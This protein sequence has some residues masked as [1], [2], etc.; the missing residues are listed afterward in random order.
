MVS[1]SM[2]QPMQSRHRRLLL[3]DGSYPYSL[4]IPSDEELLAAKKLTFGDVRLSLGNVAFETAA[5]ESIW[6]QALG[7][8]ALALSTNIPEKS[9]SHGKDP[10]DFNYNSSP[11]LSLRL[12]RRPRPSPSKDSKEEVPVMNGRE[13]VQFFAGCNHIGKIKSL[14][15]NLSPSRHFAP[16]DL[17]SVPKAKV[18]PEHYVFSSFGVLHVYP[19]QPSESMTLAEWQREAVLW[20]AV[21]AIPFFKNFLI[22][23][24]FYRWLK[25]K[26]Y[27]DY[28]RRRKTVASSLLANIPTFGAALQQVSR[29][30]KELMTVQFLPFEKDKTYQLTEYEN[31]INYKN[32]QAEHIL[33]KFFKYCKMVEDTVAEES[34]RKMKYCEEQVKKKTY[35][36]KDSLH[37]QTMKKEERE[38]NLQ[39]AKN[40]SGRLGNFVKLVDQMVVEHLFQITKSQVISFVKDVLAIDGEAQRDGFF[41]ANL[42]FNKQDV[43]CLSPSKERF[44]K[45]LSSTLNGIPAVLCSCA[46]PKDGSQQDKEFADVDSSSPHILHDPKTSSS[47]TQRDIKS[48]STFQVSLYKHDSMT[49]ITMSEQESQI[50]EG[51]VESSMIEQE[52]WA[53]TA[54]LS[55]PH[56]PRAD[57][58]TKSEDDLGIATPDL[59]LPSLSNTRLAIEGEGFLGQ[60]A[61]LSQASLEDKLTLDEE[62]Q[63]A[64]KIQQNLMQSALDEIETYCEFN[65]WLNEIHIFCRTWNEKS[66]KEFRGAVAFTIEQKLTEIRQWS[67]KVR[68]F[69]RSFI[70]ENGMFFVD[71]SAVHEGLLPCLNHIYQEL[72]AFVADEAKSLA[73]TFCEEMKIVLKNMKDKRETVESFAQFAK[74]Y[75]QYKKNTVQF[76]QRVEYI[77]SL[78]EVI[79]MSY[80]QLTAEEEK[81]EESVWSSW[82]AFLM[83]MQDAGEFIN[84][85]TPLMTQQLEETF[86]TLEKEAKHLAEQATSGC[87]LDSNQNPLLVLRMMKELREKFFRTQL[88]LQEASQWREAIVGDPYNLKF[89]SEMTVRMDVRQ[90]L[91]KYIDVSSSTIKDW[92]QMLFRKMNIKK[93]LERVTEWLS[94]AAQL[95]PYLPE[96]DKVLISWYSS[97]QDFRKDLPVLFKL[98]NDALKDRHWHAIFL[99]MNEPYMGNTQF[100]VAELMSYNLSENAELVHNVYL[101][102]IAEYDLEQLMARIKSLWQDKNF[103]IAKHI[104]DSMFVKDRAKQ[105]GSV[106][107]A[108]KMERYRQERVAATAG[109]PHGL[110][111][112]N[113]DLYVL[114]E[115]E[116]LKYQLE[117]SRISV[118][119]ML[120]SPYIGDI[121]S[122]AKEWSSALCEIEEITDLWVVCQK[123]WLYLLKI[124]EQ[125]KLYRKLSQ[126][127]FKF[128]AVHAKFKDWMRVV[129]NDSKVLSVVNRRRGEKGYRLLQGDNLC[130]LFLSLIQQ[131]D[132]IL[133][134]L[135]QYLEKHR[136][137]FPRL[138]FLSNGDLIDM[139][140]VSRS[141]QSLLPF[142]RKCFPGVTDMS[143]VLPPDLEGLNSVLDFALNSDKLQVACVKG[144]CGEEVSL[145]KRLEPHPQASAWLYNLESILKN[146]MTILLQAC[147]QVCMEEGTRQPI[148]ILEELSRSGGAQVAEM[149]EI[150]SKIRHQ[151]QHWLLHFPAQCVQI[152]DCIL[153]ERSMARILEKTDQEEMKILRCNLSAKIDQY[154]DVLHESYKNPDLDNEMQEHLSC[155]LSSLV[156]QSIHHRDVMDNL[157]K[158]R[159]VVESNFDWLKVLKF[160]MDI[161]NVLRAK[162]TVNDGG[163]QMITSPKIQPF[164]K[165]QG[166]TQKRETHEEMPH[167]SRMK[168]TVSTDYDFSP[169][170]VQQLT[171][172]FFYDYEYLGPS[173]SLVITPLTERTTLSLTQSLRSFHCSMLIGPSGTGKTDIIKH[174]AKM[175]GR[176]MFTLTCSDSVTLPVILQYMTGMVQSGCWALFDDTDHLTKGLLSVAAQQLDYLHTAFRALDLSSKNQYLIRGQPRFDKKSGVGDKVIRRNSLT[177]LHPLPRAEA[178]P[179]PEL[180]RQRTVPHGFNEKGLVTYFEDT[181][182]AEREQRRHSIEREIEIKESEL[183]KNNR[184]PPLFY[185]HV[186]AG[187]RRA[188][189][190]Y[191]KLVP[192]PS[193]VRRY[194]G[195]VMFNGKLILANSNFGGFMTMGMTGN[196]QAMFPDN[197]RLLMRPCALIKP[198]TEHIFS[199]LLRIYSFQEYVLWARKLTL[200]LQLMETKLPRKTH[201]RWSLHDVKKIVVMASAKYRDNHSLPEVP[202]KTVKE[203]DT[204]AVEERCLV[205]AL[206][207]VVGPQVAEN[208]QTTL[209]VL[210]HDLFPQVAGW[211]LK[212]E[213]S[214]KEELP[215]VEAIREVMRED[216][217]KEI[218]PL[219][220]K[221]L[222]LNEGLESHS[223]VTLVGPA[224]SGKTTCF[225]ILSRA[226]NL[227]NYKLFA[228]DHCSDELTMD[229]NIVMQS[230]PRLKILRD[231]EAQNVDVLPTDCNEDLKFKPLTD[232]KKFH[233]LKKMSSTVQSSQAAADENGSALSSCEMARYPKVDVV[234]LVPTAMEPKELLGHFRASVWK[235]G[236]LGKIALDSFFM[237]QANKIYIESLQNSDRKE[238]KL[239]RETPSVLLRW[240]VLDGDLDSSW[241]DGMKTLFDGD[242]CLS[243]ANGESIQLKDTT[244]L[245]F[246]TSSLI[247]ASPAAVSRCTVVNFGETTS[248][249][250][251]L[252]HTWKQTAK[253]RWLLTAGSMKILDDLIQDVFPA[254]IRFLQTDCC[255]AL[256]TDLGIVTARVNAMISG[257]AEVSSF[258]KM[259]SALLDRVILREDLEKKA[260]LD[261][262]RS[263]TRLGASDGKVSRQ[264]ASR[265][266][267]SSQIEAFIPHYIDNIKNM[268]A[269]AFIWSFGGHLHDRF[270]DKFSKFVHDVLYRAVHSICLPVWGQVFDYC[271]DDSTGSFIRWSDRQQDKMKPVGSAFFLTPEVERYSY[272]VDL[273]LAKNHPVLLSGAPGVGKTALVNNMV[274]SR[275]PSST[276][277]LSPGVSASLLQRSMLNHILD[278]QSK[279][280]SL[281]PG[282]GQGN[283]PSN[284]RHL[285]FIDDLNMAPTMGSYQPPV[286]LLRHILC[287]GGTYDQ[288]RQAFQQMKEASFIAAATL[289]SAAGSGLGLATHVLS[290]RLLR[291]FVNLTIF[292]PNT[293]SLLTIYSRPIQTWLEEFPAYSVEHH[294]EFAKALT[295][296]L[297]ELYN[298]VKEHLRP[299]PIH[300]HYIY[301]LHDISRVVHGILLMSPRSHI[302]KLRTHKKGDDPKLKMMGRTLSYESMRSRTVSLS[303]QT[304]Q[305]EAGGSTSVMKLITQLWCHECTRNFGDR[306][307][308]TEDRNW[309]VTVLEE[310]AVKHFCLPRDDPRL[311][312]ASIK[313]E[314]TGSCATPVHTLNS[315]VSPA[316][317]PV[318]H[319]N[320]P[321]SP[322]QTSVEMDNE[323]ATESVQNKE[324]IQKE[325]QTSAGAS[326]SVSQG[327][328]RDSKQT[329]HRSPPPEEPTEVETHKPSSDSLSTDASFTMAA[330]T[331][332]CTTTDAGNTP[333]DGSECKTTV[334]ETHMTESDCK[335]EMNAEKEG[336]DD[337]EWQHSDSSEDLSEDTSSSEES[338]TATTFSDSVKP[339]PDLLSSSWATEDPKRKDDPKSLIKN[340]QASDKAVTAPPQVSSS[341]KHLSS[342]TGGPKRGVTFKTGLIADKEDD[343]YYGPLLNVEDVKGLPRV[344]SDFVFSKYFLTCHTETMDISPEKGYLESSVDMLGEALQ[345][346]LSVYNEG[347]SQQLNLVFFSEAVHHAARLS[348]V[349]AHPQ[350]HALLLGMSY[351]TGRATLTRL[352][353]YIAHCKLFEPKPHADSTHNLA[354]VAEHMKRSCYHAGVMGKSTV[355][356]LHEDLGDQCLPDVSALMAQG[357]S[358]GLYS[359]DEVQTIVGHM[360]PGGVQ[361]KRADKIEQA[362]QRFVKRV[363]QNLHIV[364]CLNYKGNSFSSDFHSMNKKLQQHPGLLKNA[365]SVDVYH[366]WDFITFSH[367]ATTW[368]EDNKL[369]VTIPWNIARHNEQM[370][371]A[372]DAMAYIH[373][374]A[375][376]AVDRQY[377]H[378]REPLRFYSPL[379]FLEFVHLFKVISAYIVKKEKEKATKYEKALG[380]INEAFGSIA[381][382]RQEVSDLAPRHKTANDTVRSLVED[383][384]KQKQV[385][386]QSLERCKAQEE[387]ITEM[388]GPL[389]QL[390]KSAQSEFDKVNPVYEAAQRA[391]DALNPRDIDEIKSFPSPPEQVKFLMRALCLMFGKPQTWE[392]SKVLLIRENFKQ[393][394]I[395]YDKDN[396]P[397][398]IFEALKEFVHNPDFQ[399]ETM[400]NISKAASGLSTWVIAI[401]H[402]SSI[403]RKMQPHLKNLLEA[404]NKFTRVQAQ[405]GQLRVEAHGIKSVLEATIGQHKEA[406]KEA[407]TIEKTIQG[408]ERR[409]A[410]ASNLMENMSMQHFLWRAE[411]KKARRHILAA[412]GDAL[413][414][415]ACVCYHGPLDDKARQ[416]L[417]TDW[418]ERCRQGTFHMQAF[419]EYDPYSMI[420]RLEV[421]LETSSQNGHQVSEDVQSVHSGNDSNFSEASSTLHSTP[422]VR[423]FKYM[424]AIYDTSKF[425]KSELKKT[426][427]ME[428][429]QP[430]NDELQ[431]SDDEEDLSALPTRSNYTI[432]DILSDFDELSDWRMRSLPTDLHAQQNALLMRV[433][434][435]NRRHCWPLLLDP[436][437]QA[438]MWVKALQGSRNT[439]NLCDV[440]VEEDRGIPLEK[441]T[442]NSV[443]DPTEK[444]PPE[445]PPS[446]GTAL[447]LSDV[448]ERTAANSE[449]TLTS[450][451]HT[452]QGWTCHQ[453]VVK[454]ELRPVTSVTGSWDTVNLPMDTSME[455]N[456]AG[457]WVVE[458]DDPVI[459]SKLVSAI[460]HGVTVLVTHLERRPLAAVFRG[461]LLKQFYVDHE[462][463]KVV[464][465]GDMQFKIHP[466]FCLY[467]S[468]T[469]PLFLKGDGLY[470]VPIHRMCIINMAVS[471]EAIINRLLY[472]TMKVERKEFEGQRRSNENDII[473]HRQR[474]VQEHEAIR[475]KTLNLD[476]PL[477]DDGTMLES[478]MKC[479]DNVQ[480]NRII[481][482][483]TRYMG[484]HLQD[485]FTHYLPLVVNGT[486]LYNILQCL[487]VLHSVYYVPFY[488]FVD[489]FA[490]VIK[491]RDRGKGSLGAPQARAQEL[492]DAVTGAV[493][494]HASMM[495]FELHYNL[496]LLLVSLERL[497]IERKA[498]HKELSLFVNGFEKHGLDEAGILEQKPAWMDSAAWIDCSI[499][500][501]LHHPFHGLCSSLVHNKEQWREYFQLPVVL[502]NPVP[503]TTLQELSIFQKCLLWKMCCPHRMAELAQ[504]IVTYEL[505]SAA[506]PS[507]HYN[508]REVYTS[509]DQ[510]TPVV[511]ILPTEIQGLAWDAS[512]GQPY[513]SPVHEVKRLAREVGMEGKVRI[514]NFG[515][516]SQELEVRQAL[517]DCIHG[518]NWLLLQNYH[519]TT[520]LDP[521]LFIMLKDL[522]YA[523]WTE[524]ELQGEKADVSED[525]SLVTRSRPSTH[526]RCSHIHPA[527]RLWV[528]TSANARHIIPGILIQHGLRV[529]CET[530][531]NFHSTLQKTYRSATFLL[532]KLTP[533]DEESVERLTRVM[534][535]ALLHALLLHQSYFGQYAFAQPYFWTLSDLGLAIEVFRLMMLPSNSPSQVAD[536][537]ATVYANHC[538][539]S[540]DVTVVHA[541]VQDLVMQTTCPEQISGGCAGQLLRKLLQ[542][543]QVRHSLKRILDVI[544]DTSARTFSLPEQ[545]QHKLVISNSRIILS[546]LVQV[547][548]APELLLHV[549]L[550][551]TKVVG[552]H[553]S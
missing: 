251:A 116:E 319:L 359:E 86:E 176:C 390:R 254:T 529:T 37:L 454:D 528:T 59:V 538:T 304:G 240:L 211:V 46:I 492:S 34:F 277:T 91:W 255:M 22:R 236:V 415:A 263:H 404:E 227:L 190:D 481:L 440:A 268:F 545:A 306:L 224:G 63:A 137:H 241:M 510:Y 300:A 178:Q 147:V 215:L 320:S 261:E 121:E 553:K 405:L 343:T 313:E 197:F 252:Y 83:Q 4:H 309:F 290:P 385:Y 205:W 295:H 82:E 518:G 98:A 541:L 266:T 438:E 21:S 52:S 296:G 66:V 524:E 253:T 530:T 527:F 95:R 428:S 65:R 520:E 535:L 119:T 47:Q 165:T 418:M 39:K 132:E 155:L 84:T 71:C 202:R 135:E 103:K 337:D 94:A 92:K 412:P 526:L 259:F 333:K 469:T 468:T 499:L 113:D 45:V 496:L 79:R 474:L 498:S 283:V 124:F 479:R 552:S 472:E 171:N 388:Q 339:T 15:F 384:E 444:W 27:Q 285:F 29:L 329:L 228:P 550:S 25:N 201:Y 380:K 522:I 547:T 432:Q 502:L 483:E 112:A 61:P 109:A 6:N 414:T 299:T 239:Q 543:G 250:S 441:V 60:Y 424:P 409:I 513:I 298:L 274:L 101:S 305:M 284:Q 429:L 55:V 2:V 170:Y 532:S 539:D 395:F 220:Q 542:A 482:E 120:Q 153:W 525:H 245:I 187:R 14:F 301:T 246:E 192:E 106:Q 398:D 23:K 540:G 40:E 111:V 426:D 281:V 107:K 374:S 166:S 157:L 394:L 378:E 282:P 90:E 57:T 7:T 199:M 495:M 230:T 108:S 226:I 9:K 128:E 326:S 75:S 416:E 367:V 73:A 123:K 38:K 219:V 158:E 338:E 88:Q 179:S 373:L 209:S 348:R 467:L 317:T 371:M 364:V 457:L 12:S 160:R 360:M 377:C 140:G 413:I 115:V 369:S 382:Y 316:Q 297:L 466:N 425:Y 531:A 20:K 368:L 386:I 100:T 212:G 97:M 327:H 18:N 280:M 258:L 96:G 410:R 328:E 512:Q 1:L 117:D 318:H 353:A 279:A 417:I 242:H 213:D 149:A 448:T 289:P 471:D 131:Q 314:P 486:V 451:T 207:Q 551:A 186:K 162:T 497:R 8:T 452:S 214:G 477:L 24:M 77:K 56:L 446:R 145:Y 402:Y 392:D 33:E 464:R 175:L 180:E 536:L 272:L 354:V 442:Q 519:L 221:V 196:T 465:V 506:A 291:Q 488:K 110:D 144:A 168:T 470:T 453:N 104:P 352:A 308:S 269:F 355:L 164:R 231:Q 351:S 476:G 189:P 62:Y 292:T 154:V 195:N 35:F 480:H 193:Y 406:L 517:D 125:P 265:L 515:V 383:V 331:E 114:I 72:I 508:I 463:S 151:Y 68:N 533:V 336:A 276:V 391:I 93:A 546:D 204:K 17:I 356:L 434:C 232:F 53:Q 407:K 217:L 521:Q 287:T 247:D 458:A 396:I 136:A 450:Y 548:G 342:H 324:E 439:F 473:L 167:L 340:M 427:T 138:Y 288:Q 459:N 127:A 447:T 310:V 64:L 5:R 181:W 443:H 206:H 50:G 216:R 478:L 134:D 275:H 423:T 349:F 85:Q 393:D 43:L 366:P 436:D 330:T 435:H 13:A 248:H 293:D 484:D 397:D 11:P 222:E 381:E 500:E 549:R 10:L 437:N 421:L 514:M 345:T 358:P 30:L 161:R 188:A 31:N 89:L 54:S 32:I 501:S 260:R 243:L 449:C 511:F 141:P 422:Q 16:Y 102:A 362:F 67:E 346:C 19:D 143:F 244:F 534:P 361:T 3:P 433:S 347:T 376:A 334:M 78:Y 133:Q 173:P 408:I 163:K 235:G 200:F 494:H 185:E 36:S 341:Q 401:H 537:I 389:E 332:E 321:I 142:V 445:P 184:P 76:Q 148:L 51:L 475:E 322:P 210:L 172:T 225:R 126:H 460:V 315:P 323:D 229:H 363:C 325:S 491:S 48:V 365:F 509:A 303:S 273:M 544:E 357:T 26:L 379:T 270:R 286:E 234:H 139:V 70:T 129:S 490:Q 400:K 191:T 456:E 42:V 194:L 237:S 462:G 156:I 150:T 169:C 267:N 503:G 182:V 208:D 431:D 69:D 344:L 271:V 485:K 146:T 411:L 399:P 122:E 523:Q 403:Y 278:L 74:N 28:E 307:I 183:Y 294:H 152:A 370:K 489:I 238:K 430:D 198:D 174:L 375:K 118:E 80:R 81:V 249:W 203:T 312:M 493:F 41:K 256:C 87:F 335:L 105:P 350:G 58:P 233:E 257:V 507:N 455:H 159:A 99:G 461:L 44:Q 387:K 49:G 218:E 264:M 130:S 505:G 504:A 516:R 177:T 487:T 372:S 419:Q 223:P 420:A 311:E 262:S 302:R